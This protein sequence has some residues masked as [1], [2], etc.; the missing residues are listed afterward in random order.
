MKYSL[1]KHSLVLAKRILINM[2]MLW[3]VLDLI[4][5][6]CSAVSGENVDEAFMKCARSILTCIEAGEINPDKIGSGIQFG[7]LSLRELQRNNEKQPDSV[8]GCAYAKC[9][10][11]TRQQI[12]VKLFSI[13]NLFDSYLFNW[14]SLWKWKAIL[15]EIKLSFFN[16]STFN[17]I[18]LKS[19]LKF[20][21]LALSYTFR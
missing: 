6:E 13:S 18:L 2:K 16:Y 14:W 15:K 20:T 19:I 17:Q 9:L 4:F 10:I 1:N 3:F 12:N 5:V 21:T 11:W 7:D 8:S